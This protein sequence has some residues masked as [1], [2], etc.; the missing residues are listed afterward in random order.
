[1]QQFE[2]LSSDVWREDAHSGDVAAWP[3]QARHHFR[4]DGSSAGRH[5][6]RDGRCGGLQRL[7]SGLAQSG[8]DDVRFRSDQFGG[9]L[10]ISCNLRP[11]IAVL[12]DDVLVLDPAVFLE[13]TDEGVP[14]HECSGTDHRLL[15]EWSCSQVTD[16]IYR[17]D[18]LCASREW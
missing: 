3:R 16:A 1:M 10:R 17:L 7:D 5:D 14:E 4:P 2:P 15:F 11:G 13:T 9:E 12:K 18:G 6:D 8:D